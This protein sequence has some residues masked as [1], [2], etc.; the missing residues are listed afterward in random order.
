MLLKV[1]FTARSSFGAAA[2]SFSC[3]RPRRPL[4]MKRKITRSAKLVI[5]R[6]LA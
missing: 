5:T 4:S 3:N 1:P 6:V 2:N